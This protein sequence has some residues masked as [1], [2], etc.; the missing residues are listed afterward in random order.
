MSILKQVID[1]L[2]KST[3]EYVPKGAKEK[4]P[5]L[6]EIAVEKARKEEGTKLEKELL[7]SKNEENRNPL[8]KLVSNEEVRWKATEE[9]EDHQR[10]E[11]E[12]IVGATYGQHALSPNHEDEESHQVYLSHNHKNSSERHYN[13]STSVKDIYNQH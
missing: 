8:E 11:V 12:K 5:I 13:S 7:K 10:K 3:K 2:F 9:A 6:K 1:S 4:S